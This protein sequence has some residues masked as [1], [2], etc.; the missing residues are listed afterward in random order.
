VE[1]RELFVDTSAWLPL[2]L[3]RHADHAA[4]TAALRKRIA[5]GDRIVTTNLVLA[6]SY[7]LLV[8]RGHRDAALTFL[9]SARTAPNLVVTSTAELEHAALN[10]WLERFDDQRFS[11]TDAVSFAV[12]RERGIARAL[13]LD[14]HFAVA[15]FETLPTSRR[16]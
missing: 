15:G 10:D 6:E 9:A 11:F 1:S 14:N 5:A 12:M 8:Y 16:R 4:L 2:L 3:R 13:T 7:T